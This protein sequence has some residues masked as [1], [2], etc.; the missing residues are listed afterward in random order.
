LKRAVSISIG[1]S[2]RD[3]KAE[4][5]LLGERVQIERIGTDG[6]ME[7][8]TQLY[9]QLDGHVDAFGVGGAD[10]DLCV[11]DRTYPFPQI[12]RMIAG[13][14]KTPVVDGGGLQ[15]TLECEVMQ[16]VER[17]IGGFISPRTCLIPS[18]ASR[19]GM[20]QSVVRAGYD[21]VFG[22]LMFSLG[23]PIPLRTL[24]A[25]RRVVRAIMPI[26]T[27]VPLDW[28]YP[29]GEKQSE[30]VPKWGKHYHWA[31]VIASDF[32]YIKRH[33][34][35]AMKGKVIVTNT[36]TTA[37]VQ[38]LRERGVAYLVTTTPRLAGRSFGANAMEAAL[39]AAAGKG[40]PLTRQEIQE[41]LDRL[42]YQPSLEKL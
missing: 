30:V 17:E 6:D 35:P 24:S 23:L 42:E 40:R 37:D 25:V 10:L 11:A 7:K 39:V 20:A 31:T 33:I 12:Y 15:N 21:I 2:E 3:H 14:K 1:S 34:P 36:T 5:E 26:V 27:R 19:Y 28:L 13:V 8:A 38:L 22:D 18:A 32:L 16:F 41:I 29:T 4:I 9:N